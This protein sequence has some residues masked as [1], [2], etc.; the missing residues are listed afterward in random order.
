MELTLPVLRRCIGEAETG[1]VLSP[2]RSETFCVDLS[3]TKCELHFLWYCH[4]SWVVCSASEV[5]ENRLFLRDCSREKFQKKLHACAPDTIVFVV[6]VCLPA[7]FVQE[8]EAAFSAVLLYIL[9][10][11]TLPDKVNSRDAVQVPVSTFWGRRFSQV[12]L[13]SKIL[14]NPLSLKQTEEMDV[15]LL[16]NF[17]TETSFP[18]INNFKPKRVLTN[19]CQFILTVLAHTWKFGYC[20]SL[21]VGVTFSKCQLGKLNYIQFFQVSVFHFPHNLIFEVWTTNHW[22]HLQENICSCRLLWSWRK[23]TKK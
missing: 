8:Q 2:S 15:H 21:F 13:T 16:I 23:T 20:K 4:K 6:C 1:F 9:T 3:N 14:H 17:E 18:A 7:S 12:Q 10:A 22:V 5:Q 11:K 19:I